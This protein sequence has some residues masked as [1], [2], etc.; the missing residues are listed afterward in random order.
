MT[1]LN[2]FGR[3]DGPC[4]VFHDHCPFDGSAHV[5]FD[6]LDLSFLYTS[7]GC[8]LVRLDHDGNSGRGCAICFGCGDGDAPDFDLYK[9]EHIILGIQQYYSWSP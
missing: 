7:L 9:R 1:Q 3:N 6:N 4:L 8:H 5:R 2:G